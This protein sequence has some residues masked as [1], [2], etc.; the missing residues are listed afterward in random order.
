TPARTGWSGRCEQLALEVYL[1]SELEDATWPCADHL[2]EV[3]I[4]RCSLIVDIIVHWARYAC[5][6]GRIEAILRMIESI[7]SLDTKLEANSFGEFKC[8][9][10]AQVPVVDTR[11]TENVAATIAKLP[12]Q[13]L[14]E[15][16]GVEPV[17]EIL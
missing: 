16:R 3:L 15:T 17:G 1:A 4:R 14:C 7:E 5:S 11:S 8:L 12:G 6:C 13:R 2:A 9:V 10:K